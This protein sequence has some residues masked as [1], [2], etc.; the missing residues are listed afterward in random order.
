MFLRIYYQYDVERL[1][2][3]TL[4][5]HGLLHIC[6]NIRFCGPVWTTWT[7]WMERYCG[8]LQAGLKSRTHP[9][10]NLNNRV[11]HK[12][13]LEQIDIYYD[14]QDG[15]TITSS[16]DLKRGEK[17]FDMC[18]WPKYKFYFMNLKYNDSRPTLY[19][20]PALSTL[21]STRKNVTVKNRPLLDRCDQ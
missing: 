12:A 5:I 3:C 16:T 17:I 2:T 11:L 14:L 9:W 10:A 7:F 21:F 6:D 20:T 8:Y 18:R 1:S 4:T 19:F 15:L 13:Y